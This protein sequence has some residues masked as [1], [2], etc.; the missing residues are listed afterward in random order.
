MLAQQ[1]LHRWAVAQVPAGGRHRGTVCMRSQSPLPP[2]G[3]QRALVTLVSHRS[4]DDVCHQAGRELH[5]AFHYLMPRQHLPGHWPDSR[6][7]RQ[8]SLPPRPPEGAVRT[9][10][11]GGVGGCQQEAGLSTP[12]LQRTRARL[13]GRVLRTQLGKIAANLSCW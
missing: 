10:A 11:V 6:S 1:L 3:P 13:G 12:R 9:G 8:L 2:S 5:P 4:S 7:G